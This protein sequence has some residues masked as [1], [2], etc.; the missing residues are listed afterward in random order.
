LILFFAPPR[1]LDSFANLLRTGKAN[2]SSFET[3]GALP[4]RYGVLSHVRPDL[5]E[6]N[7]E[8]QSTFEF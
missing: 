3:L 5:R 2:L 1:L 6:F 8:G 7:P 4:C